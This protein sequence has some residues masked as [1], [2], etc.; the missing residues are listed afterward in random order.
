MKSEADVLTRITT[1]AR[2]E[3]CVRAVILSGSRAYPEGQ[4]DFLSDYDLALYVTDWNQFQEGDNWLNSF[5]S[6]LVRWPLVPCSTF[7]SNWLTPLVLF[8]D[9]VRIDFQITEAL[10]IISKVL[11]KSRVTHA[12][13]RSHQCSVYGKFVSSV[14]LIGLV[15]A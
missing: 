2:D 13:L 7:D 14:C 12:I 4:P 3:T 8:K 1:W 11:V 5:G 10:N 6:I 9:G 15:D